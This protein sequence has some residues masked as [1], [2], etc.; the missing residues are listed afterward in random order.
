MLLKIFFVKTTLSDITIIVWALKS[1]N[2]LQ[3]TSHVIY[4]FTEELFWRKNT[5]QHTKNFFFG[6]NKWSFLNSFLIDLIC[7]QTSWCSDGWL[8]MCVYQ[9]Q[10]KSSLREAKLERKD[11]RICRSILPSQL[12]HKQTTTGPLQIWISF[13]PI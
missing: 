4:R 13:V 8:S 7:C 6:R 3:F 12:W 10:L 11:K 1:L 2:T 9:C 5:I